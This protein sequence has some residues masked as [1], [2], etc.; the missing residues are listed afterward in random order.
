MKYDY[1]Q[2]LIDVQKKSNI[3]VHSIKDL[4]MLKVELESYIE[5]PIGFNTLRRLFGFLPT[6]NPSISTLNALSKYLGF[7]SFPNYKNHQSNYSEWYFQQNLL[8]LQSQNNISAE[9]IE[10]IN[11]GLRDENNL[12]YLAYFIAFQIEKNNINNLQTLFKHINVSSISHTQLHKLSTIV[13]TSLINAPE[14]KAIALY[15]LLI[16]ND[17]FRNNITLPY[18]DYLHLNSRYSKVLALIE[19]QAANSSDLLFVTLMKF[20]KH[21][22]SEND[23]C[24]TYRIE[25]PHGFTNFYSVLKGRYYAY[26]IMQS[27]QISKKLKNEI[28]AECLNIK[29][30]FFFEE[31]IP[32]LVIKSEYDF[33]ME[34]FD[35]Y[36]EELL[37]S[38]VWSTTTSNA[39][40]LI[41]LANINWK[42]NQISSAKVNLE[43]INLEQV[44]LG[45]YEYISLFY[46][47]TKLKISYSEFDHKENNINYKKL[48]SL[49]ERTNFTKFL[50]ISKAYQLT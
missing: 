33:L 29:I 22:Y 39:L 10:E 49:V 1:A 15:T 13:I 30:S 46:Y 19:I 23:T 43:L 35:R 50:T 40:Y 45:Y 24:Y 37:E 2:L 12:V 21:F 20:Y 26:C 6:T 3:S 48:Y 17:I 14:D 42:N 28:Y 34:I 16:S 9:A 4:K 32:S 18:I 25:K 47:L 7:S 31:I 38:D 44:E 27:K 11:I 8:R 5:K 41:G 36:Y